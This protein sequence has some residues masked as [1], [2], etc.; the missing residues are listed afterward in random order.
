MSASIDPI[1][2]PLSSETLRL[3]EDQLSNNGVVDDETLQ[4]FFVVNG[5]TEFQAT[6]ALRY[7]SLYLLNIF[8]EGHTPIVKGK[9]ALRFD[10]KRK[11]FEIISQ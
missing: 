2:S 8:L 9:N 4:Q 10:P 6:R 3:V 1:L 11:Q 7:R 5:L